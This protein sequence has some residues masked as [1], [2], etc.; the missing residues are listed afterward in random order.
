MIRLMFK[1][2]CFEMFDDLVLPLNI[3]SIIYLSHLID[4]W[5]ATG[6][7]EAYELDTR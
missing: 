2:H 7:V 3:D 6:S 4:E 1:P 5:L